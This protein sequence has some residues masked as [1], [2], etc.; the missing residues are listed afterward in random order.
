MLAYLHIHLSL[1]ICNLCVKLILGL[2]M[3]L[4]TKTIRLWSIRLFV[5]W[6]VLLQ[7]AYENVYIPLLLYSMEVRFLVLSAVEEEEDKI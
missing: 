2:P 6:L 1:H 5:Y 7:F 3:Y 4:S